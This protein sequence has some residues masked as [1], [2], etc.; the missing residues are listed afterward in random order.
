MAYIKW[1]DSL[2]VGI[3]LIDSQH[4]QM[5]SCI[6]ELTDAMREGKALKEIDRIV[7]FLRDYA[8]TH[9]A[10]EEEL[11][12]KYAYPAAQSHTNQHESFRREVAQVER[13]LEAGVAP[14]LL[15]ARVR[16]SLADWFASHINDTDRSLGRFIKMRQ[17]S[18]AE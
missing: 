8:N 17:R 4:K 15:C 14:G 13:E 7:E 11:M 16:K 10:A 1:I 2:S 3:E 9:F 5:I 18:A 12:A 6:N